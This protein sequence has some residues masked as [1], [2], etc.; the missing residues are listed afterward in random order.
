MEVTKIAYVAATGH[1]RSVPDR[2]HTQ[3]SMI[4]C[5]TVTTALTMLWMSHKGLS[6]HR[7]LLRNTI[8]LG[9][10]LDFCTGEFT[11]NG[12]Y[13][14]RVDPIRAFGRGLLTA[15]L[16][17]LI[18]RGLRMRAGIPH[19]LTIFCGLVDLT[20]PVAAYLFF[21]RPDKSRVDYHNVRADDWNTRH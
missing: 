2:T 12:P 6:R 18:R 8:W 1:F 10:F 19:R 3:T 4:F 16:F 17:L 21:Y 15:S 9:L 13:E 14:H 5:Y 20:G 7:T 11:Y